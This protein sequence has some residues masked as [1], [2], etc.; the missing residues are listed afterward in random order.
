MNEK[1][2]TIA[3]YNENAEY[4][5][6]K[7]NGMPTRVED[8]DRAFG[9]VSKLNPSVV[10][11]GSGSGREAAYILTKTS[12]YIGIDPADKIVEIAKQDVPGA[13]FIVAD[14][15]T[16]DYPNGIDIVFSFAS[17]HYFDKNALGRILKRIHYSLNSRGI[18]YISIKL[19]ND[20]KV[21]KDDFGERTFYYY[22]LEV[23]SELVEELCRVIY[24][25]T[26]Y[27]VQQDWLTIVLQ[28]N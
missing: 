25:S 27:S 3:A 12:N 26:Q 19:G 4:M 11:I 24:W 8:I 14:A 23:I 16:Y 7:F 6:K 9:F 22:N 21:V 13:T 20:R 10:E 15:E 18:V 2:K 17:L 5:T 1:E 28:K